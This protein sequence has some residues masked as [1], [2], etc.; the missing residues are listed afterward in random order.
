MAKAAVVKPPVPASNTY[1]TDK[2]Y[3]EVYDRIGCS[4]GLIF[5]DTPEETRVIKSIYKKFASESIVQ[6]WS[7]SQGLIEI[8]NPKDNNPDFWPHDFPASRARNTKGGQ[9]TRASLVNAFTCIEE[10]ARDKLLAAKTYSTEPTR[11]IYILRDAYPFFQQPGI[12]RSLRD[13]VYLVSMGSSSIVITGFGQTIPNDL[14][15]DSVF[16]RLA[17]PKMDEIKNRMLPMISRK[18]QRINKGA[19]PEEMLEETFDVTN[20]AHA[21]AGLTE[22]QILNTLTF[23][24][25]KTKK[26]DLGIINTEK[27]GIINKSDILDYW[28]CNDTLKEIGGFEEL[29]EWFEVK[30]TV[31]NSPF[32]SKFG[33]EKPKGIMLL[34]MQGSGK[35]AIAKAVAQ[36]WG[37]GLIKMD[38]GKVFAGLVGESEKRMRQALAQVDA[39]G[40][41]VVIDEIDKGLSGAGSSDRTDGGT[42]SRVIGTLL[43]W[44]SEPHEGVFLIATANDITNLKNNH[45]ELLRKGRFDEIFFSDAP[46][47]D[48]RKA[49]FA[50]H[51]EK[52]G[53]DVK[54]F[55][56]DEL[57]SLSYIDTAEGKHFDYTGA[58]IE[59]AIIDAI[60]QAFA[61]GG[62]ED[63]VIG[64]PKD[65]TT[66]LIAEKL[67]LVRPISFVAKDTITTMR[68]WSK[69]NARNVSRS[70]TKKKTNE[71]LGNKRVDIRGA[72]DEI[73]I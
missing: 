50:I 55:D 27:K 16:I 32:A 52:R 49:I 31:M 53:R 33:A 73:D 65:V 60:Q 3:V 6:F 9:T 47:E 71:T 17:Y 67:S 42:T 15:K 59:Y 43:T 54:K 46:T 37:V 61:N 35:T 23:S 4:T 10:D 1:E 69:T 57:A 68:R 2:S 72:V 40:G 25:T 8:P 63:L 13:I 51:L 22:E 19:K 39:V 66:K 24:L 45:P 58:E 29:K 21:C 70:D 28:I 34:G 64:G 62:G 56:L 38:M 20:A 7:A 12:L 26:I 30:K 41:V 48:E 11:T 36:S 18:I 5:V 14:E 44:L